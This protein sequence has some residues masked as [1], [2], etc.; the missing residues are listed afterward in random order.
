MICS[1]RLTSASTFV[2]PGDL[3]AQLRELVLDL[4]ALE[5]GQAAQAH[6][7]DRVGLDLREAEALDEAGLGLGVVVARADD[8]DDLVDVVQRDDVALEDVGALLGLAQLVLRAP[9]DD[10]LLVL[11]VVVQ[12]LL[13]RSACA[14]RRRRAT[15]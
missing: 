14:A 2:V 10:V 6:L 15:A 8:L 4:V 13:E 12:H 5:A 11:D 3:L 1:T 9:G 7:E